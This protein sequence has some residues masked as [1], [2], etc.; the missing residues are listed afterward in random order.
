MNRKNLF[1]IILSVCV[2]FLFSITVYANSGSFSSTY[3][4]T[5]G[6]AGYGILDSR[7]FNLGTNNRFVS[8]ELSP[9]RFNTG[10]LT[11]SLMRRGPLGGWSSVAGSSM[12]FNRTSRSIR[13]AHGGNSGTHRLR[14]AATGSSLNPAVSNIWG[15]W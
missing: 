12:T 2:M 1:R 11:A 10:N 4:I 5:P 9:T 13:A 8:V 14:I 6:T 7:E 15:G 3:H